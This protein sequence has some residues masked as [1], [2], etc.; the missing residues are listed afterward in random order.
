[1]AAA[2]EDG[3]ENGTAGPDEHTSLINQH[4]RRVTTNDDG[5]PYYKDSRP[6]VRYP[7]LIGHITYE[8]LITNYVNILLVFVPLGIVAGATGWNPTAVFI[9]NFFAIIPLASLLAY[10]TEELAVPLG[11]TIGGLLN[12]TFGNAVELIV[13][14]CIPVSFT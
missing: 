3:G 5:T 4:V 1:M 6:W 9:L 14:C 12:A 7:F 10:A 13:S 8:I 11:Q 2:G